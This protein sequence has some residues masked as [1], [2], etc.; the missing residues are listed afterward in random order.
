M[1]YKEPAEIDYGDYGPDDDGSSYRQI[2]GA[3][4]KAVDLG[5]GAFGEALMALILKE[6]DR[7]HLGP[8]QVL[9]TTEACWSGYSEYTITSTWSEVVLGVVDWNW[10]KRW[11]SL[12]EF[13]KALAEA[14]DSA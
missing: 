3:V 11:E 13:L 4:T 2:F 5:D 7:T 9:M 6:T 10:E 12:P 1:R 14:V 8:R